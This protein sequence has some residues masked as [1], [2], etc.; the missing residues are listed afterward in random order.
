MG[1]TTAATSS[2]GA[3]T[4]RTGSFGTELAYQWLLGPKDRFA[5]VLGFGLKRHRRYTETDQ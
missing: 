3:E 5:T 2:G 1:S 4:A